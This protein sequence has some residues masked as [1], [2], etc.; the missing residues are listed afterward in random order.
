MPSSLSPC[1]R[2]ADA[3]VAAADEVVYKESQ[4]QYI[5]DCDLQYAVA[6]SGMSAVACLQPPSASYSS[7]P[8]RVDEEAAEAAE[9]A[10]AL[11]AVEEFEKR[12]HS[13]SRANALLAQARA[14]EAKAAEAVAA[15]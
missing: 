15:E 8:S 9:V 10:A 4:V 11:A 6:G 12:K 13:A 3:E 7:H 5:G 2:S 1:R 14:A